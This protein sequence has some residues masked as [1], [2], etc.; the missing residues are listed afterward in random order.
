MF[1]LRGLPCRTSA[2]KGGGGD[3]SWTGVLIMVVDAIV[4]FASTLHSGAALRVIEAELAG[5]V[6]GTKMPNYCVMS[7]TTNVA[8]QMMKHGDGMRILMSEASKILLDQ[9]G[10]FRCEH[11]GELDLKVRSNVK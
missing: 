10:G 4:R 9:V 5:V 6:V 11:G 3:R 7:D 1:A 2:L 8:R